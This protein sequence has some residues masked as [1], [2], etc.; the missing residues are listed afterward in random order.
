MNGNRAGAILV[1][2]FVVVAGCGGN[3]A[4]GTTLDAASE[5]PAQTTDIS[6]FYRVT[7][8][9]EGACSATMPWTLGSPIL[10]VEHQVSRYVVRA[11]S[12]PTAADCTGT[13]F[14]D[15]TMPIENGWKAEGAIALF[16]AGCTLTLELT[17]LTLA[18]TDLHAKSFTY[19]VNRDIP[20]T[21]CNLAAA[22]LL[23]DPCVH[24]VDILAT[25]L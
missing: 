15:F 24:E 6:G 19:R 22:R 13:Y 16:S 17:D 8:D 20:Q 4:S 7:S 2:V 23:T 10:W 9:L 14:N 5:T 3:A 25:R 12:G 18:G 1:L 11:C 21:E